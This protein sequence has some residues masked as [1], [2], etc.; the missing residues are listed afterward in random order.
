MSQKRIVSNP[1]LRIA[2]GISIRVR[3]AS[4]AQIA[5]VK[6]A[7]ARRGLGFN[8]YLQS[9]LQAVSEQVMAA[10]LT[11]SLGH[12]LEAENSQTK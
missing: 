12:L 2:D 4:H 5:L 8:F 11:T 10:P 6:T 7:A 3:F 1:S 9:V